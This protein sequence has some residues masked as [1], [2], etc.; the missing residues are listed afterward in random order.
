MKSSGRP[1]NAGLEKMRGEPADCVQDADVTDA[2]TPRAGCCAL[3]KDERLR[4][5]G[6][7]HVRA[8]VPGLQL[9]PLPLH[10]VLTYELRRLSSP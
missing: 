7:E 6:A 3:E 10:A 9:A 8:Y 4:A 1:G 5:L 2:L